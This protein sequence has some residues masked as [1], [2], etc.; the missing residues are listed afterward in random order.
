MWGVVRAIE[1]WFFMNWCKVHL[2]GMEWGQLVARIPCCKVMEMLEIG[3]SSVKVAGTAWGAWSRRA[4]ALQQPGFEIRGYRRCGEW[5]LP[6]WVRNQSVYI[7]EKYNKPRQERSL[8]FLWR[9]PCTLYSSVFLFFL[10][11]FFLFVTSFSCWLIPKWSC[12][13]LNLFEFFFFF[14]LISI[15]A[16][17]VYVL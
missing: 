4:P 2:T 14:F 5:K 16:R 8:I 9:I 10:I 17:V 11:F 6:L 3:R 1:T 7:N 12:G 13:V 15:Y